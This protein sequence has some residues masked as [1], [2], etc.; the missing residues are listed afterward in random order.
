MNRPL[1]TGF[2][3]ACLCGAMAAGCSPSPGAETTSS[4]PPVSA[5][6][7]PTITATPAAPSP[8]TT[9]PAMNTTTP[10]SPA[11]ELLAAMTLPQKAAQVLLLTIDGTSVN[12]STEELLAEGPPGGIL[13][14]GHNVEDA[15][16]TRALTQG[17]QATAASSGSGV[18]LFVAVDQEGG[19]VQR[20][21]DGVPEVPGARQL[22]QISS[23]EEAAFLAAGTAKGL[24]ALGV[25]MNLAPVADV[26][27]NPESFLYPRTFGGDPEIVSAFVSAITEA[28]VRGGLISVVKHFPGHGSA[29]GNTHGEA[30]V[31]QA[32]RAEFN[33]IH[34]PPFRAAVAA[35]A[36]GV[37]MAHIVAAAYDERQPASQS[38]VVIENLLREE[39]GFPGLVVSDDL[40]M[41]AATGSAAAGAGDGSDA[42]DARALGDAAVAS[43]NAGCDL[44][45]CTGTLARNLQVR[46]AI[47]NAIENGSIS[48]ARLDEAVSAVLKLKLERQIAIPADTPQS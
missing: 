26:V 21:Q 19:L 22:G 6:A 16:Q 24:L 3:V 13:L 10:P 14:L 8:S 30:V 47:V 5:E 43:I 28:Y 7:P 20:V 34:L 33:T 9:L 37:M 15:E 1:T 39:L 41:A 32:T 4:P 40:E 31:S 12:S 29:L 18:A 23:P 35:G 44:L 25:N 36:Q 11:E 38:D 46:D 48:E 42:A 27:S 2:V 17:L 45:I